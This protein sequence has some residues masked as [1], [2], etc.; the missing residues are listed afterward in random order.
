MTSDRARQLLAAASLA[1]MAVTA[2]AAETQ[3][4]G[5]GGT[6]I[7]P[8]LANWA[9]QYHD[10]T[11][12][13]V[14]YQPIGSGGG[15]QQIEVKTV[16]FANSD[17]PLASATLRANHLIQ[18]PALIIGIT[19]VVDIPG[20]KAGEIILS[21]SLLADIY[22]GEITYWDD[23]RIVALNPGLL[24]PHLRII[25]VHR[26]DGSG[27]TFNFTNYLSKVS[28]VWREKVGAGTAVSW[29]NGVGGKGNAGVASFVKQIRGSIG[30]VEYA[31]T[32]ETRLTWTRM[33]NRDGKTISPNL[34]SFAA[35]AQH[36][37]FAKTTDFNL[38]LTN[39]PGAD[40]WPITA[41]TYIL[42]RSDYPR[43][44]NQAV[45]EFCR[46]FLSH[47]QEQARRLNYVPL[48]AATV[49]II[50]RYWQKELGF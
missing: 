39:E 43:A 32:Q 40:T 6:A 37:G 48:P 12:V 21:G 11:G 17:M 2:C 7:Y 19:P 47:G 41:T 33:L 25:T 16:A 29:P 27:T 49:E 26:S 50:V 35:A 4:A 10:L 28:P 1:V 22:L 38:T 20:I 5:A 14:N 42:M 30:Y 8:V 3:L 44:D 18:F 23:P 31:F 34:E 9:A 15:I 36:A 46:W 13:A 24:L 45:I